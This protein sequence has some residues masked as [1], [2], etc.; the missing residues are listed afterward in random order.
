MY[1]ALIFWFS[2]S[3][4]DTSPFSIKLT[5]HLRRLAENARI[6]CDARRNE[7]ILKQK[8]EVNHL[9]RKRL[10][11]IEA[12]NSNS[13]NKLVEAVEEEDDDDPFS[14]KQ[15]SSDSET[16]DPLGMMASVMDDGENTDILF[17]GSEG[18]PVRDRKSASASKQR[19]SARTAKFS[20]LNVLASIEGKGVTL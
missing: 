5:K 18:T 15:D 16:S 9:V 2:S 3:C 7:F 17:D 20:K 12:L 14:R 13:K 11:E 6:R 4:L 19:A 8:S 1:V 10:A